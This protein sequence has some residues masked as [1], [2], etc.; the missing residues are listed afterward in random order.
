MVS[1]RGE[2]VAPVAVAVLV[3]GAKV[4]V[5]KFQVI[6]DVGADG[7]GVCNVSY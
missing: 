1:D 3:V 2:L 6:F 7:L 4:D 5:V